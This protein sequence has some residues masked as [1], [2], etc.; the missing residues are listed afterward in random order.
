MTHKEL[1]NLEEEVALRPLLK[2]LH[3]VDVNYSDKPDACISYEGK[4]I[5]NEVVS[6]HRSEANMGAIS[7]LNDSLKKYENIINL[8]GERGKQITVMIDEEQAISYT[9]S[10]EEQLF[11]DIENSINGEE[12]SS[13]YVLF[14]DSDPILPPNEKCFVARGGIAICQEVSIDKLQ[15]IIDKKDV[16]LQQYKSLSNNQALNEYWL[17]IYVNQHEYDYFKGLQLPK[18]RSQFNRIYLTHSSDGVL[19]IKSET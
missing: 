16:R 4:K 18:M 15:G 13:Q 7:A 8:R 1:Q 19:L 12:I 11:K 9:K 14:A 17:V 5:G 6:Y 10:D 2:E 3:I